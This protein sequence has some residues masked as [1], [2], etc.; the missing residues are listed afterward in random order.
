M[1]NTRRANGHVPA[2][3]GG[4][5]P[6][7]PSPDVAEQNVANVIGQAVAVHLA[8]LLASWQPQQ[9]ACTFCVSVRKQ[10]EQAYAVA[11]ANAQ[12][13]AEEPP[14]PA[15]PDVGHAVTWQP[16][17]LSANMPPVA[18]P[19]CYLHHQGGPPARQVGLVDASGRPIV[20][21]G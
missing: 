1:S 3:L 18:V 21:R 12:A 8:K 6:V 20:A 19:V 13:A 11:V 7:P 9:V 16:V 15:F 5:Q 10:A 2:G 4:G 14:Q 17:Q